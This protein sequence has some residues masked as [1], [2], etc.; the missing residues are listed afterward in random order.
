L[1]VS[2][3]GYHAWASRP[4]CRGEQRR[5]E[6]LAAI[7]EVHAQFKGR[8]GSPRMTAELRDRGHDCTENTV[9]KLMHEN[10]IRARTA[11]ST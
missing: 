9:A 2:E 7:R 4:A 1:E 6:L 11:A 8:Y 3:S 5:G 10:G